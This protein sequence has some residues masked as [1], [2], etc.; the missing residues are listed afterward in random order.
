[1]NISEIMARVPTVARLY[2]G[3]SPARRYLRASTDAAHHGEAL[4]HRSHMVRE[5]ER[6][7]AEALSKAAPKGEENKNG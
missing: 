6:L 4:I 1:M 3:G 2:Y 7:Q 5:L